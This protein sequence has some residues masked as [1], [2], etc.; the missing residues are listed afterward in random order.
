V[1]SHAQKDSSYYG[2]RKFY[3]ALQVSSI[4]KTR[5]AADSFSFHAIQLQG[6]L[7]IVLRPSKI[8]RPYGQFGFGLYKQQFGHYFYD[9]TLDIYANSIVSSF[10][11][12]PELGVEISPEETWYFRLGIKAP[13]IA[14][15]SIQHDELLQIF[16]LLEKGQLNLQ[17]KDFRV[18]VEVGRD[19]L[20][21]RLDINGS[22]F[23]GLSPLA[24][25]GTPDKANVFGLQVG[26]RYHFG[27]L[28][29]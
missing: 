26:L 2:T 1:S 6:D 13:L 12:Q 24:T 20:H 4:S 25:I 14:K 23:Y 5:N 10:V 17:K 19:L 11:L 29:H 7:G 21:Q 28:V 15:L 8:L 18:N 27:A 22:L 9:S 16:H 3:S